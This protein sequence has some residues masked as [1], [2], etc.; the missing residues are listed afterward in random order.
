LTAFST[1]RPATRLIGPTM[2]VVSTA[3]MIGAHALE[4]PVGRAACHGVDR[5]AGF[6]YLLSSATTAAIAR[7]ASG[8]SPAKLSPAQASPRS[9][10]VTGLERSLS[11]Q[12][13]C[14]PA[15]IARAGLA[16][17]FL[18]TF[19]IGFVATAQ[20]QPAAAKDVIFARKT[21]MDSICEKMTA[22]E[23]M[24]SQRRIDFEYARREADAMS[25]MLLAFPHLFPPSS[26]QWN[27]NVD[28]DPE[29]DTYASP[30]LWTG[31]SDFYQRSAAAANS[32][33]DLSRADKI[34]DVKTR[35]RELRIICD[36]CHAL[37]SELQ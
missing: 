13:H 5:S 12:R 27:P 20:D 7:W 6:P 8:P 11:P 10:K 32:A 15:A 33:H 14:V 1:K 18:A 21:L 35:A 29:T 4:R 31:F 28:P 26:N 2:T 19:V 36:T 17:A 34:D 16:A 3:P 25:A 24:I 30:E 37:H 22:I 23:T 9:R